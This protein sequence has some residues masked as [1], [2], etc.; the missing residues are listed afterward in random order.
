MEALELAWNAV[1][2]EFLLSSR[3]VTVRMVSC[4][5]SITAGKVPTLSWPQQA[6]QRMHIDDGL[7]AVEF[8][9]HRLVDGIAQPLVA[10]VGLQMVPSAGLPPGCFRLSAIP[11]MTTGASR[12]IKEASAS[13][14]W[15]SPCASITQDQSGSRPAVSPR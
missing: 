15:K 1:R 12:M 8:L 3:L 9:Q 14:P 5:T 4:G 6:D 2:C 10:V 11:R 13:P 7:A